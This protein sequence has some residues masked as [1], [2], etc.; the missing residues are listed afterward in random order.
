V[1][2]EAIIEFGNEGR[3]VKISSGA[4]QAKKIILAVD[5]LASN[6]TKLKEILCDEYDVRLMKPRK[7]SNRAEEHTSILSRLTYFTW[8]PAASRRLWPK[9]RAKRLRS[10]EA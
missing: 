8:S 5:D 6:L 4:K 3:A 7:S 1:Q 10:E 2:N 9:T